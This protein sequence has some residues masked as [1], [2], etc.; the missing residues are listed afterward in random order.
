M[1]ASRES[2]GQ[3]AG[4]SA[5][6]NRDTT[7][8]KPTVAVMGLGIMGSGMAR[9]ALE[10]GFPLVVYNRSPQRAEPLVQQ[11]ARAARTPREAASQASIL[12][13]M[14]A[15]D[16]ASRA[17]WLAE[18]GALA[19]ARPGSVLI[20]SSTLSVSWV[21]Q[22]HAAAR[23]VACDLLDAPVTGS[24]PQAQSGE[25]NFLV[26]GDPAALERARPVLQVMGK[27]IHH[28][29]PCGSGA[30]VKLINNF[31]AG[32]QVA[33]L[34][35]AMALLEWAG[36]NEQ[37][38]REKALNVLLNGATASPVVKVVAARMAAHDYTP[39]FLLKLMAKDL[40]YALSEARQ[41]GLTLSTP[42]TAL[43]LMKR[44]IAAGHGEQ[45]MAAVVEIL[46]N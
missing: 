16:H 38:D 36:K 37:L 25:L 15:D 5:P 20:E 6:N 40:D 9:R 7:M 27:G 1:A 24:K 35:E 4:E 31:M 19:G 29:G 3:A 32:V 26:G 10:A 42:A 33:A 23:K 44:A 41:R 17:I 8:N 43:E 34:A 12:I 21:R 46:R 39:N 45:D 11:G 28:L 13:S 30:M 14:V 22:L 2:A 18:D